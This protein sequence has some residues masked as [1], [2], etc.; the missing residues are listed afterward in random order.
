MVL[1]ANI[2][3]S[4]PIKYHFW[5]CQQVSQYSQHMPCAVLLVNITY[6]T[7]SKY[8]LWCHQQILFT[9]PRTNTVYG[10]P[11][12]CCFMLLLTNIYSTASKFSLSRKSRKLISSTNVRITIHKAFAI[13]LKIMNETLN[14]VV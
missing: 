4:N 7:P 10:T 5:Y 3:P 9:V 8:H 6:I 13:H 11:S 1:P 2:I 12:K 14:L